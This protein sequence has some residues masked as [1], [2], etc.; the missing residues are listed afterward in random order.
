MQNLKIILASGSIYRKQLLSQLGLEFTVVV[1]NIDE[2]SL[3]NEAPERLAI[4]LARQKAEAV[5]QHYSN[6]IIIGSDQV[7]ICD[8]KQLH[9]PGNHEKNIQQLQ[10]LSGR[11]A[12]FYTGLVVLNSQTEQSLETFDYCEVSFKTLT[13]AQISRYVDKDQ[14]YYC[15]GGFKAE[16]LGVALFKEMNCEDPNALIGLPLIKLCAMLETFGVE[17]I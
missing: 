15:A 9:K 8:Q 2:L 5:Q 3:T 11:K 12:E 16:S 17:I 13:Q 14:A 4:R 1:P 6:H 7:A 10:S